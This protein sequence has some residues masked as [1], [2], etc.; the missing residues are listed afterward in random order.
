MEL[1]AEHEP[2]AHPRAD[3]QE[4]E[5]VDAACDAPP[6]LPERGEVDVVLEPHR[7]PEPRLEGVRERRAL[8]PGDVRRERDRAPLRVDDAGHA[9][10][11][12][13]QEPVV[14]AGRLDERRPEAGDL[15]EDARGVGM[16]DL[17]VEAGPDVAAEVAD[18]AAEEATADVEPERERRLGDGL[19]ED[20]PVARA[21]AGPS[22][23]S[24]TSP[25]SRSDWSASDTVGFEIPARR[26]I[27]AREMGAPERIASSTVRTFRCLR[28]GGSAGAE[29]WDFGFMGVLGWDPNQMSRPA[30]S[31]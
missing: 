8:E 26:E 7:E 18:R 6:L 31:P 4:E 11:D 12:A 3:R 16:L 17:D 20:R 21:A 23:A 30:L 1:A 22:A 15:G 27:S 9:D 14:Q 2:G 29:T 19:E 13:V 25:A 5:V 10:D 24:R 28:S